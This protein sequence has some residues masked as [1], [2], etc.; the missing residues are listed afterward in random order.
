MQEIKRRDF[1]YATGAAVA[2]GSIL[3]RGADRKIRV[4]VWGT[5]HG[6]V[7][8]KLRTLLDS[9][10]YEVVAVHEPDEAARLKRKDD[11]LFQGL[12]WV[13]EEELLQD[14]SIEVVVVECWIWEAIPWGKKVIAA[15]KHL[16]LEKPPSNEMAPFQALV[17][18]ARRKELL[19]QMGYV[20]RFHPSL[21]AAFEAARKGW[22]G[23]VYMLRGTIN[24]DLDAEDRLQWNRY[25]GGTM[26]EL[27]GHVI[28]RIVD[29]WGS[30]RSV[31]PWLR[32]DTLN[33][34]LADNTMAVFEYDE[35]LAVAYSAVRMAGSG[36]HRSF[37]VI[38]TDGS[39]VIQPAEPGSRAQVVM[40][41]AHGPYKRGWQ[42]VE[43]PPHRRYIGD[44]VDLARALK[45][46]EPLR[47]GYDYE[48]KL[49]DA[50]LRASG[51]EV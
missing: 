5:K 28:D 4:G 7:N 19:V 1:L 44:F 12:R 11:P 36:Q 32:N 30:P 47:Y 49:Q 17:E 35:G 45:N 9:P 41:E 31:R 24:K 39:F 38:G 15:G 2:A 42:T 25:K 40:R 43:F 16:H 18:E 51:E 33:D 8:G 6:H 27:G 26:F 22:L 50:L 14:S 20:W 48:L 13:S 37:E 29:F 34:G 46:N 21:E 10:D 23:D 3:G